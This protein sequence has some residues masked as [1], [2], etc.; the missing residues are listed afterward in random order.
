MVAEPIGVQT[1]KTP[2][3]FEKAS[4][5]YPE[6]KSVSLFQ[7]W[8]YEALHELSSEVSL[9]FEPLNDEYTYN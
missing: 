2:T 9:T 4:S 8:L 1:R 7:M 6:K 3:G 5:Q